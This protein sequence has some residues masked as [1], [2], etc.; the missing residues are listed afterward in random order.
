MKR[1]L[2]ALLLVLLSTSQGVTGQL[3][4]GDITGNAATATNAATLSGAKFLAVKGASAA[5]ATGDS[6]NVT[7]ICDTTII[8][9]GAGYDYTTGK[10]TA[11]T[12]GYYQLSYGILV[13]GLGA[14]HTTHVLSLVI[15]GTSARNIN[16]E[17]YFT[18]NPYASFRSYQRTIIVPMT[19][20]DIAYVTIAISGSTKTVNVYGS[21][22]SVYT[23]FS[24]VQL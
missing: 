20:G 9:I 3:F 18:T 2:L 13:S 4:R 16:Q 21:G 12:T 8:N 7:V 5:N 10:F 11:P 17:D 1:L 14:A 22:A 15:T 23:F 19:A 24:G 6:T